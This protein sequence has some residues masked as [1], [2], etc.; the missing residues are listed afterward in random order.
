[1]T[2][3]VTGAAGFI[4]M[5]V[6]LRLLE[7]GERVVGIDRLDAY[8]PVALKRARLHELERHRG[9]AFH[10]LDLADADALRG[11]LRGERVRRIVHLAAQP[12]VRHSL[13]NPQAYVSANVAGH[14]NVLEWARQADG[15]EGMVYASSSSVYGGNTK[16]PFSEEDA[17]D[18]PISLY[19]ATKRSGEL[20]AHTYAH[21]F[22]IPL[23]GL[24]FFTVYGPWGRPD[25][26]VWRFTEAILAGRPI[27]VFNHGDMMR[28][29]TYVDD[30]VSGVVAASDAPPSGDGQE[31]PH[32]LYNIGNN[33]PE[34]LTHLIAVIEKALGRRA[35]RVLEPMQPGDVPATFADIDRIRADHGFAP[36]TSLE[37]GIPRFVDWF[38][39]YRDGA[40]RSQ[41]SPHPFAGD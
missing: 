1:M 33:R 26:A 38:M 10:R 41:A 3:L 27:R 29:F 2:T 40:A 37:D 30:I 25:M 7:R 15:L 20:M 6:A 13:E 22:R 18:T 14:V 31:P 35:E 11:A 36:T 17:V 4:G 32:R 28:D 19:A 5:H 24:R 39:A 34:R 12:G 16:L 23:T 9:F 8:Y 21:L